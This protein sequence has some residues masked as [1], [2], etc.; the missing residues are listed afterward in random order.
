MSQLWGWPLRGFLPPRTLLRTCRDGRAGMAGNGR[1]S[2]SATAD[3]L[4][5]QG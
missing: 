3:D 4:E 1:Q 5:A 2:A